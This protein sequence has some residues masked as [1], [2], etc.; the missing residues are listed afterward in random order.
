MQCRVGTGKWMSNSIEVAYILAGGKSQRFGQSK[1]RYQ[2]DGKPAIVRLSEQLR[3]SGL[4]VLAVS[5]SVGEFDDVGI[6]TIADPVSQSG[7]LAGVYAAILD[8]QSKSLSGGIVLS[9][10]LFCWRSHWLSLFSG[11]I[12]DGVLAVSLTGADDGNRFI[13][14]PAYYRVEL[15]PMLSRQIKSEDR[16]L[17]SLWRSLGSSAVHAVCEDSLLPQTFNTMD[18]FHAIVNHA[19]EEPQ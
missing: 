17:R 16:S 18:E 10:D 15:L 13:P 8:C 19:S 4:D 14:M 12:R 11:G 2:I 1:A 6:R 3:R 9:C 5:Q 7:P